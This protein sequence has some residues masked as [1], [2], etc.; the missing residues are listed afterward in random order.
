MQQMVQDTT[1]IGFNEPMN[2]AIG[3]CDRCCVIFS[4]HDVK[5]VHYRNLKFVDTPTEATLRYGKRKEGVP[6]RTSILNDMDGSLSG[7]PPGWFSN[8]L[9]ASNSCWWQA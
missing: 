2:Y 3:T 9:L 1:F 7:Y 8:T 6:V 4:N 5:T